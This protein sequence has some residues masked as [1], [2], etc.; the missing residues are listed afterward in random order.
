MP[1]GPAHL[2]PRWKSSRP[3]SA[4]E[5]AVGTAVVI[6]HNVFQALPNEVPILC[7]VGLLSVR[8]RDGGLAAIGLARP[9]SWRSVALLALAAAAARI[10]L[11]DLVVDPLTARVWPPAIAPE[12]AS[13]IHGDLVQAAK[14]LALVWTFAAFG[15]EVAYRG[16]LQLRGADLG[17]RTSA[18]HW[19]AIIFASALF[20]VGHY[21]KG[22]PGMIDSGIAG[23]I[24]GAAFLLSGRCL[25]TSI[26]AHGFIDTFAVIALFLGW[27]S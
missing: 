13:E 27:D 9:A 1:L 4:F 24:L 23:L 14:W 3:L 6:G 10:L 20:G 2:R 19:A 5:L 17:R 22:P 18:A 7:A 16:Y 11:G 15:E 21:Y 25:W 26:L 12:G 8:L